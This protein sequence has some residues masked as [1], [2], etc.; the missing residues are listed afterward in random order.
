M[1]VAVFALV[2]G[3]V[4]LFESGGLVAYLVVIGLAQAAFVQVYEE[5]TLRETYGP[6][7]DE[8]CENVPRWLPRLTPW[9]GTT[10][11]RS[12]HRMRRAV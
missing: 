5:P 8:F 4:L 7:Y 1:Y 6:A 10:S 2:L 3:Q 11:A 12:R 9:T